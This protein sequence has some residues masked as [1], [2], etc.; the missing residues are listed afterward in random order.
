[1]WLS[2]IPE[3]PKHAYAAQTAGLIAI[4]KS[5]MVSATH[6]V[7]MDNYLADLFLPFGAA[8]LGGTTGLVINSISILEFNCETNC[9]F[10]IL[11]GRDVLTKGIF[12]IS[13]DGHFSFA[14]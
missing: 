6:T 11:L 13:F 10:Q 7:D 12:T 9:P 3:L 2:L 14:I 1:L 8:P 4:G 5:P